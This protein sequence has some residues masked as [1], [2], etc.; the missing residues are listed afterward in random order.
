MYMLA[1]LITSKPNQEYTYILGIP[2]DVIISI[3]TILAVAY[4]AK[5]FMA[6]RRSN[7]LKTVPTLIMKY[8]PSPNSTSSM[9]LVNLT[10]KIAYNVKI[11][12]VY[13]RN[14]S[15]GCI[16]KVN[17]ALQ[18]ENYINPTQT[19]VLKEL[20]LKDGAKHEEN[21]FADIVSAIGPS[22]NFP[23]IIKFTDIQGI[24]YF[25]VVGFKE[26]D[27]QIIRPPKKLSFLWRTRLWI[28]SQRRYRRYR[29]NQSRKFARAHP[30]LLSD[31]QAHSKKMTLDL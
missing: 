8:R 29:R 18:G 27:V 10:S 12:P 20:K 31:K 22:K 15:D 3:F 24:N 14:F 2:L 1:S 11:A 19:R 28:R 21:N 16:Y 30:D 17:F 4:A 26:G 25:T 5:L 9:E 13:F 23:V 6:S 7:E